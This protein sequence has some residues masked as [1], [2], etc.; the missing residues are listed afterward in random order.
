MSNKTA[1][2]SAGLHFI[3]FHSLLQKYGSKYLSN[4]ALSLKYSSYTKNFSSLEKMEATSQ[5][6]LT[7]RLKNVGKKRFWDCKHLSDIQ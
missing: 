6:N 4:I 7:F 1:A 3:S 5:F 2:F